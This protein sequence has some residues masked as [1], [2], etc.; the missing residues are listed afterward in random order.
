M[1]EAL[2]DVREATGE[3]VAHVGFVERLHELDAHLARTARQR[4]EHAA[5]AFDLE[6]RL[7]ELLEAELVAP[8]AKG[9]F[10]VVDQYADMADAVQHESCRSALAGLAS[11]TRAPRD[12]VTSPG[13]SRSSSSRCL[14]RLGKAVCLRRRV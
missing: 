4:Q 9:R 1:I 13:Q 2:A 5:D 12:G 6:P 14:L 3:G 11:T 8:D 7:G 10:D